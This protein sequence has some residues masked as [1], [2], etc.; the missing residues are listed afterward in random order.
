MDQNIKMYPYYYAA[1]SFMAFLPIFFL[2]FSSMLSLKDVL[3]LE[4]IY[5]IAV[6]ILEV[7]TGY[8]SDLI[9]RRIT[10]VLGSLMLCFAC[11]VF[12]IATDFY[13][14]AIG[15]VLFA[16][17]MALVS[18]T[19]TVFHYES[20]KSLG[21][22]ASY[23]DREAMVNQYGM[24]AGGTAALLGGWAATY[25]LSAAYIVSLVAGIIALMI[26]LKF[27]EP[28]KS[29]SEGKAMSSMLSQISGTAL[30]LR[31]SYLLWIFSFYVVVYIITHVPYEFYQPYL[32]ILDE[33]DML[34]GFSVPIVSGVLYAGARYAGAFGAR[35]SMIWSRKFGLL[36]FLMACLLLI[37]LIVGL[38]GFFLNSVVIMAVLFR[39]LP[40]AAI[41]AP[42]NAII[43]PAIEAGQRA[44][45]HSMLSLV[46]RLSFFLTLILLS[47]LTDQKISGWPQLSYL[48]KVCFVIGLIIA[49][50]LVVT[51]A[52]VL[53]DKREG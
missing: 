4:S 21:Q 31:K 15:Q 42:L 51:G 16:L 13:I 44:T 12:L 17:H 19:N 5:Y 46:N 33:K 41:K 8:I 45:F 50:P 14:L 22:E 1:T 32:K 9:G 18:G 38:M 40:W 2:Y 30:Y 26:A 24:L 28:T 6:V 20:L 27:T 39:S 7:P 53:S 3:L 47:S 35:Y 48:L 52:R 36:T 43:T 11:V 37:N 34:L 25:A 10:L 49:V 23:G 29:S